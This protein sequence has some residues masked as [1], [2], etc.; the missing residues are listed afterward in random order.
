MY[1][2]IYPRGSDITE[3]IQSSS[4]SNILFIIMLWGTNIDNV[5]LNKKV[6]IIVQEK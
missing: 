3:T 1:N 6:W 2:T 4:F 5:L